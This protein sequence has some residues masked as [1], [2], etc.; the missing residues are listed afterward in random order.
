MKKTS[1]LMCS[2]IALTFTLS[3]CQGYMNWANRV[4]SHMPVYE[5]WFGDDKDE[6]AAAE[7]QQSQQMPAQPP[8]EAGTPPPS[9]MEAYE[10]SYQQQMQQNYQGS[11]QQIQPYAPQGYGQP[12]MQ[13]PQQPNTQSYYYPYPGQPQN[14]G[15]Y[16][17]YE[18]QAAHIDGYD[19]PGEEVSFEEDLPKGDSS[20]TYVNKVVSEPAGTPASESQSLPENLPIEPIALPAEK[21]PE[22]PAAKESNWFSDVWKS[23][24]FWEEDTVDTAPALT[25]NVPVE[26]SYPNLG[27]IPATPQYE[28]YKTQFN[29]EREN[30]IAERE[31]ALAT[32]KTI[33]EEPSEVAKPAE[34]SPAPVVLAHE[35]PKAAQ[36]P[37]EKI[38]HQEELPVLKPVK[39][40]RVAAQA[41]VAFAPLET[42]SPQGAAPVLTAPAPQTPPL[43][44][45]TLKAPKMPEVRLLEPSR[46][47]ARRMNAQEPLSPNERR[48]YRAR[49]YQ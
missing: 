15:G 19:A 9:P 13:Q 43:S 47:A 6:K 37:V 26:E 39:Q 17:E 40:E 20:K 11:Q 45:P 25:S 7:Q 35:E 30:L 48:I 24:A 38:A 41:P 2:A 32:Q 23:I 31:K 27:E 49:S 5:D 28:R 29:T 1:L 46:Y 22:Q 42:S 18:Q 8:Y 10:R 14:Q 36:E 21:L 4:G 33:G 44:A 16:V 3:G 12:Q 34:T